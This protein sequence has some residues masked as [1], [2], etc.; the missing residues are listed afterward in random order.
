MQ[1]TVNTRQISKNLQTQT[2]KV[3]LTTCEYKIFT[4][5]TTLTC[6]KM[7]RTWPNGLILCNP[8][9]A[10]KWGVSYVWCIAVPL[11]IQMYLK[12]ARLAYTYT[13]STWIWPWGKEVANLLWMSN[14]IVILFPLHFIF[15]DLAKRQKST[16]FR[17]YAWSKLPSISLQWWQFGAQMQNPGRRMTI[18]LEYLNS[19]SNFLKV[20]LGLWIRIFIW[21]AAIQR[22]STIATYQSL[23]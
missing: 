18:A 1:G 8:K 5:Q 13:H 12:C 15:Q 3:K 14:L 23:M 4:Y 2:P 21:M 22:V 10:Q 16:I 9:D 20:L 6:M 17:I 7:H 11:D 19:S